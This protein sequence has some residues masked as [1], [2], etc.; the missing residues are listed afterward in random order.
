MW[1]S[2]NMIDPIHTDLFKLSTHYNYQQHW[3]P[4]NEDHIVVKS[5]MKPVIQKIKLTK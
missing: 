3:L 2:T 4:V 1:G 5:Q